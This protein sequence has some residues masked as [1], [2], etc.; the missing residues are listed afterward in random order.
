MRFLLFFALLAFAP[1]AQAQTVYRC[2]DSYSNSPCAGATVVATEDARSAA[3]RAQAD[4]ATRRD[5]KLAQGL[6]KDRLRLEARPAAPVILATA[7]IGP[8]ALPAGKPLAKGKLN[9]PE[10]FSA[11]SPKKPGEAAPQATK[12][13]KSETA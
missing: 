8:A 2:G 3:Q 4:A 10:Q 9:K 7:P 5:V 12:K 1:P 11:V 6:E 13:K